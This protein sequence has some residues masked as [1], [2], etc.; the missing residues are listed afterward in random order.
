MANVQGKRYQCSSCGAEVLITRGGDG[1]VVCCGQEMQ[2]RGAAAA[3]T[4]KQ[5][6]VKRG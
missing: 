3:A 4:A 6:E 2:L 1:S 5:G